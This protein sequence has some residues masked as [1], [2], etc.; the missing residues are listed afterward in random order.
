MSADKSFLE[1]VYPAMQKA[2]DWTIK[3]LHETRSDPEFPGLLPKAL[4]DGEYLWEGKNH[5][6]GYDFWNLRGLLVTA[7]AARILGR[8]AIG[9]VSVLS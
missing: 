4:A 9:S 3:T 2:V 6:L 1:R 7:D 5:I 8:S